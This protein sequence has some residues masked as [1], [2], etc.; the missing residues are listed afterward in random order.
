M[1][2]AKD[3]KDELTVGMDL[4]VEM[5]DGGIP[6]DKALRRLALPMISRARGMREV[7]LHSLLM[8][9]VRPRYRVDDCGR[10]LEP[11]AKEAKRVEEVA[12]KAKFVLDAL[13]RS[14]RMEQVVQENP[15]R[16]AT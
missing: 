14:G 12:E 11:S 8:A 1:S 5:D 13:V 2:E 16:S 10:P 15:A 6:T 4:V 7:D 9:A 3:R